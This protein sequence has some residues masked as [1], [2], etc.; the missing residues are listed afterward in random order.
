MLKLQPGYTARAPEKYCASIILLLLVGFFVFENHGLINEQLDDAYISYR[1]AENFANGLGLVYN[2]GERVEGYTNLLWVL[3]V[4][5]G[6]KVGFLADRFGFGLSMASSI[7]LLIA[8]HSYARTILPPDKRWLAPLAPAVLFAS[9][10]FTLWSA[11]GMETP[12]FA[13]IAVCGFIAAHQSRRRL[14][15][16]CCILSVLTRP[17]GVLLAAVL[18]GVPLLRA[19]AQHHGRVL[20]WRYWSE[21]SIFAAACLGLTLWRLYY[22]GE[23]VPNTY[24]AKV[25]GLPQG[26]GISYIL[27]FLLD[28]A[29]FLIP[30]FIV[31][32]R[33]AGG[34]WLESTFL[35]IISCYCYVVAGDVFPF[36]RFFLPVLP[37]LIGGALLG[38]AVSMSRPKWLPAICIAFVASSLVCYIY[39]P[40]VKYFDNTMDFEY[41]TSLSPAKRA[42]AKGQARNFVSNHAAA[43]RRVARIQKVVSSDALIA[44]VAIGRLGYLMPNPVLD[45]VGLTNKAI[46]HSG[47]EI[48]SAVLIPGHQRTNADYVFSRSPEVILI[49]E[50]G[51]TDAPL[52]AFSDLWAHDGL[53]YYRYDQSIA[54]YKRV[55]DSG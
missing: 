40:R 9:Q 8:T 25:G 35:A 34:L 41:S 14:V 22:Y 24:Y 20:Q 19:I 10:S 5:L 47:T 7:A 21:V 15:V 38:I 31:A 55:H 29:L 42:F 33:L 11:A 53:R 44:A 46:S 28:G 37:L 13:L 49:P 26:L 18:L 6:V 54:G 51:T 52:P 1:Y 17:D 50:K 4:S 43:Q 45:L 16:L 32:A 23:V 39:G 2:P 30:P 27:L 36:S 3:L 12:L 48:Q